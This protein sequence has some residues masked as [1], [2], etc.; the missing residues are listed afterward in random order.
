MNA[1]YFQVRSQSDA[2]YPST[3]E[4]WSYYLTNN[5]GTPPSPLWDPLQY[6]L[7]ETKKRGMEFHA[8]INPYRAVATA[9]NQNNTA[10]YSATHVSRTHPEWMLTV[11]TVK[12]LN[13]GL[14]E[15]RDH[16][17]NVIV[18]IVKRYDVDGN[19]TK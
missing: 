6:A 1:A 15:V 13:P 18:D 17:T 7:D 10:Q 12:I 14:A 3:L 4:P 19:S 5:Q 2:M 9:A 8:W 11:G 16:V